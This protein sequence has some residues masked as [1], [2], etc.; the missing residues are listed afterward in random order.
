MS[1]RY[2][3]TPTAGGVFHMLPNE[4]MAAT[5]L[6]VGRRHV[7]SLDLV[8]SWR[9]AGCWRRYRMGYYNGNGAR[10]V[11]TVLPQAALPQKGCW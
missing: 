11:A 7:Q 8:E 2:V 9:W 10:K 1:I 4:R 3:S 6:P 5:N